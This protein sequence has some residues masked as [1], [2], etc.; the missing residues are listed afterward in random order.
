MTYIALVLWGLLMIAAAFYTQRARHPE[1]K[2]LAAYLIFITLFS[3]VTFF[4]FGSFT[5]LLEAAGW[6]GLLESW[7]GSLFFL[8]TVFLPAFV[9]ARWQLKKPPRRPRMP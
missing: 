8:A 1:A 2:P 4:L 9:I 5:F 3:A 6:T 7:S